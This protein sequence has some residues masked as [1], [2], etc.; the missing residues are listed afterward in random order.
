MRKLCSTVVKVAV[1]VI[2][3]VALMFLVGMRRKS[4]LVQDRV[5]RFNKKVGNPKQMQTA[6]QP[7]AWTSVVRHVGR[8]SGTA[9]ETPV[10][11]HATD[12]GLLISLP[13]G[14]VTDWV[15]NV[16]AAGRATIVR[17]GETFEV[18][19]PEL[20]PVSTVMDRLPKREQIV[21]RLFDVR[22]CLQVRRVR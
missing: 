4:P 7:G 22:E 20:M 5:R 1:G 6:G 16:L 12:D 17:D 19:C 2:V 14:P 11:A 10:E 18:D 9:Y 8:A 13:Y 15:K 21:L 3:L